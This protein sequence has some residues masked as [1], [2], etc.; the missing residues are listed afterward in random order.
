MTFYLGHPERSEGSA[1]GKQIH[2]FAQDDRVRG[3]T[4]INDDAREPAGDIRRTVSGPMWHG[5]ALAEVLKG[6]SPAAAATR[7]VGGAHSIWEL[8]LHIAAWADIAR[9]RLGPSIV[10]DPVPSKN[11]PPVPTPSLATWR[12]AVE[13]V[14]SSYNELATQIASLDGESLRQLVPGRD[15][16]VLTMVRGVIEHG[17]YHGGQI[18]ILKKALTHR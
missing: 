1:A 15:Y 17:T 12:Q 6:I 7:P 8:V 18:A 3:T 5:P 16:T 11:W 9:T 14:E 2:R 10:R 13:R 4:M